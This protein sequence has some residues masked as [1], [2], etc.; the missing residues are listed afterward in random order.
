V[1]RLAPGEKVVQDEHFE[2]FTVAETLKIA[3]I[4]QFPTKSWIPKHKYQI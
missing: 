2:L 3:E 1:L 4:L